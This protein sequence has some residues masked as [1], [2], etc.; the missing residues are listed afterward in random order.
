MEARPGHSLFWALHA[1]TVLC[2]SI[3]IDAW[4]SLDILDANLRPGLVKDCCVRVFDND[5]LIAAACSC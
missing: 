4:C 3:L 1:V 2:S 5:I